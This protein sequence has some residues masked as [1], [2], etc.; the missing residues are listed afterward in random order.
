MRGILKLERSTEKSVSERMRKQY[1]IWGGQGHGETEGEFQTGWKVKLEKNSLEIGGEQ[2]SIQ[3]SE[4]QEW[5]QESESLSEGGLRKQIWG[6]EE[7]HSWEIWVEMRQRENPRRKAEKVWKKQRS[8][9]KGKGMNDD[10][11]G[12]IHWECHEID[13]CWGTQNPVW[14]KFCL[15]TESAS[16]T[17]PWS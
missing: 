8:V 1:K 13:A 16:F 3:F 17:S 9:W 6:K 11:E 15:L 7:K 12:V 2:A 14:C 5:L 4:W 10:G